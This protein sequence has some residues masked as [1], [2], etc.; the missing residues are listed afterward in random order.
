MYHVARRLV[1]K[2]EL[3]LLS[4]T[5]HPLAIEKKREIN[6][7]EIPVSNAVRVGNLGLYYTVNT[8][9][10][11][12][13]IKWA[14]EKEDI[15]IIIHCNILPSLM[16]SKLARRCKIPNIYDYVDHYPQSASA[17]YS[18]GKRIVEKSVWMFVQE[19]LLSSDVV[20]TPSYSFRKVVE[21]I[22]N[23]KRTCVIPNGVDADV[24]KPMDKDSVRKQIGLDSDYYVALIAGSI[25]PWIEIEAVFR[26]VSKLRGTADLRLVIAGHSHSRFFLNHM[27]K[28]A[29]HYEIHKYLYFFSPQPYEKSLCS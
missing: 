1:N 3:Y 29:R 9:Q 26:T 24:F 20:V 11:Y 12:N 7:V 23:I 8:I 17:Y 13:A 25:D 22:A 10:I 18:R 5:G 14:I 2:Y 28:L 21:H 4:Y 6:A 15:D 27:F 19:T 16:A